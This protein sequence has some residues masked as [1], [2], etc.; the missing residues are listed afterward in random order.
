VVEPLSLEEILVAL[1]RKGR[2]KGAAHA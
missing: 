1:L 2:A